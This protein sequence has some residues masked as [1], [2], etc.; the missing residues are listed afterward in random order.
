M[1]IVVFSDLY[2]NGASGGIPVSISAQKRALEKLGHKVTVFYPSKEP[3]DD[4]TEI[5]VP[6]NKLLSSFGLP[7]AKL[8]RNL[9]DYVLEKMK[10]LG[11]VDVIHVHYELMAS[12]VGM[13]IARKMDIPLVVTMHGREDVAIK[14]NLP[15]PLG[16]ISS[17]GLAT[18]HKAVIPHKTKLKKDKSLTKSL[19]MKNMWEI[20]VN[21]AN[22]ADAVITP[23]R[24]FAERLKH[25]GVKR[26]ITAVSNGVEDEFI[27][28]LGDVPVRKWEKDEP[29][30]IIWASRVSKEK[31]PME[32]LRAVRK[33]KF[34]VRVDIFGD[35]AS[36][37]TA[38][39]YIS[40]N[41]MSKFVK[42]RGRVS[43]ERIIK[44]MVGHHMMI[45]NSYGFDTQSITLLEG[46]ATG[47]PPIF[48]D[49]DMK[50]VVPRDGYLFVES[51]KVT[52]MIQALNKLYEEPERIEQMSR[53][54]L[55]R[56]G[57]VLQS[58]QT[59]KL[60]KVY[61]SASRS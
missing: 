34:P 47:L 50:E 49:P 59:D 51:P 22:Y 28:K 9:V 44:E 1:N 15:Q 12:L 35:G 42:V 55:V 54:L 29:L 2:N 56:R 7:M 13:K 52:A 33:L 60:L 58:A 27:E 4:P 38:K 41:K 16:L 37:N 30:R 31:R 11:K 21:H 53:A 3:S 23:S 32:F 6:I 45:V 17:A 20:M 25:Y 24:H 19:T 48:V 57:E 18:L 39:T 8:P 10:P 26:P 46:V 61:E 43:Q 40:M 5:V 36:I 14:V